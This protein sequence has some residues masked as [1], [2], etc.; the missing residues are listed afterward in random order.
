MELYIAHQLRRTALA[1]QR[2]CPTC[3]PASSSPV[4]SIRPGGRDSS[5]RLARSNLPTGTNPLIAAVRCGGTPVFS[6]L[7]AIS[8]RS[9][10]DKSRLLSPMTRPARRNRVCSSTSSGSAQSK[11]RK[12]E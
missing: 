5:H 3:S 1:F 4:P 10:M 8:S 6:I 2:P 7:R 11:P 9:G 12:A